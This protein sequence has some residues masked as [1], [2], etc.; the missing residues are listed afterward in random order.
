MSGVDVNP[1]GFDIIDNNGEAVAPGQEQPPIAPQPGPPIAR[2]RAAR[3]IEQPG[4]SHNTD[5]PPPLASNKDSRGASLVP[6]QSIPILAKMILEPYSKIIEKTGHIYLPEHQSTIEY[7]GEESICATAD[8]SD[9]LILYSVHSELDAALGFN[10]ETVTAPAELVSVVYNQAKRAFVPKLTEKGEAMMSSLRSPVNDSAVIRSLLPA[11]PAEQRYFQAI[12]T[13]WLASSD[14]VVYH[15]EAMPLRLLCLMHSLM[16]HEWY[17]SKTQLLLSLNFFGDGFV[18]EKK[19]VSEALKADDSS[20]L[21]IGSAEGTSNLYITTC[22]KFVVS[23]VARNAKWS[24]D[25]VVVPVRVAWLTEH[26]LIAYILGFTSTRWWNHAYRYKWFLNDSRFASTASERPNDTQ[27]MLW[28]SAYPKGCTVVIDGAFREI[29]LVV[30]D[31]IGGPTEGYTRGRENYVWLMGEEFDHANQPYTKMADIFYHLL[32]RKTVAYSAGFTI[33]EELIRQAL[34]HFTSH[35]STAASMQKIHTYCAMLLGTFTAG[36]TVSTAQGSGD[37]NGVRNFNIDRKSSDNKVAKGEVPDMSVP[38]GD[39][40]FIEQFLGQWA[41]WRV[42]CLGLFSHSAAYIGNQAGHDKNR[43]MLHKW[44]N[45]VPYWRVTTMSPEVRILMHDG[46]FSNFQTE[47][48]SWPQGK[49]YDIFNYVHAHSSL[50][51]GLTNWALAET[52]T[53]LMDANKMTSMYNKSYKTTFIDVLHLLTDNFFDSS[54]GLRSSFTRT[55]DFQKIFK[56]VTGSTAT[57]N[58]Y[59][60][61]YGLF[62]PYWY[63]EGLI[64]KF[65]VTVP[66]VTRGIDTIVWNSATADEYDPDAVNGRRTMFD[67]SYGI[68]NWNDINLMTC[69][70]MYEKRVTKAT[71]GLFLIHFP[72]R[73]WNN[74]AP[75]LMPW[76]PYT[77]ND[78]HRFLL[79][80]L[81]VN[82]EPRPSVVSDGVIETMMMVRPDA[83]IGWCSNNCPNVYIDEWC[84][85]RRNN[86][87]TWYHVDVLLPDPV[88]DWLTTGVMNIAPFLL[89]GDLHG[90]ALATGVYLADTGYKW[91]SDLF[92][93]RNDAA[94]HVGQNDYDET[95]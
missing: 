57:V 5:T 62:M 88:W 4:P 46:V 84:T 44:K 92:R 35:M 83:R 71:Q 63:I 38:K 87:D 11:P 52:G 7:R 13:N 23:R 67:C 60:V 14:Q 42:N 91:L 50:L 21:Q 51:A 78:T 37:F 45:A 25:A 2:P 48:G 81:G 93:Q 26:W 6:P 85:Q 3:S 77:Q 30:M 17:E 41:F 66:M 86:T 8:M 39:D 69:T 74:H 80:R 54:L 73:D 76:F 10:Y 75:T 16:N 40:D 19:L 68:G 58:I 55:T 15:E 18:F 94:E 72:N 12:M 20:S 22:K 34:K 24:N 56:M 29:V 90:A 1:D 95:R 36:Y 89:K 33:D 82:N 28:V 64:K 59:D 32:E 27:K 53:T 49:A 65:G 9:P 47:S 79:R 31:D 61:Y 43:T 70:L